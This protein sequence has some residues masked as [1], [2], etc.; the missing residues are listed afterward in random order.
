M[1]RSDFCTRPTGFRNERPV[2]RFAVPGNTDAEKHYVLAK[3]DIYDIRD[4]IR[5]STAK[6][7]KVARANRFLLRSCIVMTCSAF[8]LYVHELL[9]LS[10]FYMNTGRIKNRTEEYKDFVGDKGPYGMGAESRF[11]RDLKKRYGKETLSNPSCFLLYL[12]YMG[13]PVSEIS[14][15]AL[16]RYNARAGMIRT[17]TSLDDEMNK[18]YK[19][20]CLIA[21]SYDY[22]IPNGQEEISEEFA[23]G[24]GHLLNAVVETLTEYVK[25]NW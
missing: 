4:S 3:G 15:K 7:D 12:Q 25:R 23:E 10:F 11:F 8:D 5:L 24:Y 18:F 22:D 2:R 17:V 21:H 9:Y 19:R 14:E 20:R 6:A 1:N 13:F 16:A